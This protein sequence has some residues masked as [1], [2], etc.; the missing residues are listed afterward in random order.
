MKKLLD[1]KNIKI[2]DESSLNCYAQNSPVAITAAFKTR[3]KSMVY[4]SELIKWTALHFTFKMLKKSN[5]I[6]HFREKN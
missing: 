6:A 4:E 2:E 1:L 5:Q 3:Y